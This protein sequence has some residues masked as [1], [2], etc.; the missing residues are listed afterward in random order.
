MNEKTKSL[1]WATAK[2]GGGFL[3]I[4]L[5]APL[6]LAGLQGLTALTAAGALAVFAIF[7]W[8][9][10]IQAAATG[11]LLSLKWLAR[12]NPI[13][14]KE[15]RLRELRQ[16]IQDKASEL[17]KVMAEVD[18]FKKL[19]Q[20][21]PADERGEFEKE[22]ERSLAA[23]ESVK[24]SLRAQ[25]LKADNYEAG[26]KRAR[27]RWEAGKALNKLKKLTGRAAENQMKQILD[28]EADSAIEREL[29]EGLA[30]MD[31]S[32]ILA[33]A[34]AISHNPSPVLDVQAVELKDKVR[35]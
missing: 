6:I 32:A 23:I 29:S 21:M 8:P 33:E 17:Q 28:E 18:A 12:S 34:K 22:V 35:A 2:Y 20:A 30:A 7:G 26:L 10:L 19:V 5:L 13:E 24:A 3:M 27:R 9:V 15:L 25:V 31:I 16:E 11:Q 14:T 4:A 1:L